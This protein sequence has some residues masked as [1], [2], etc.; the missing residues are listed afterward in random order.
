MAM[1]IPDFVRPT[2]QR[3]DVALDEAQLERLARYLDLLLEANRRVNLTAVREPEA[4]WHR[5]ILD[6]L[7]LAPGLEPLGEGAA[8]I[9]IGSGGGLPGIPLAIARP[10][11]H[12]TLLEAT[13]KKAR[14]LQQCVD[15]LPLTNAHVLNDRAEHVGQ[16]AAH[17]Q[18]YELAMARAVGS[19]AEVLEYALPLVK[20][21]GRVLA[22][23]GK[24]GE[25]ELAAAG[26]ALSVLGA[27]EVQVIEAYPDEPADPAARELIV[28]SVVKDRPT[29]RAYP[30]RA[31]LP[32]HEP[33]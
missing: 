18:R 30:R 11:L 5:L 1:S 17:R 24:A 26:D 32:R 14:F 29:P 31:G 2:L 9:D 8:L 13:G 22:M 28:I 19:V 10:D 25:S 23:K 4:A 20:V 12:F 16:D 6:S 21:G 7:T 33:L 27:G 3:L 15:E